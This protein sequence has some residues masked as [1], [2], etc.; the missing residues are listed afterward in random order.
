MRKQRLWK[1]RV[2]WVSLTLSIKYEISTSLP[3]QVIIKDKSKGKKSK[4]AAKA[5]PGKY[6]WEIMQSL[7]M[8]DEEIAK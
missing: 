2:R 6:Q 7:G 5:G 3:T 1:K 8:K 4:A